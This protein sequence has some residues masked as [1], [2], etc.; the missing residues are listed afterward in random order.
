MSESNVPEE[1]KSK[2]A[3][4]IAEEW[5]GDKSRYEKEW[6][7]DSGPPTWEDMKKAA[8][9]GKPRK[10]SKSIRNSLGSVEKV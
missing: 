8:A 5:L 2:K 10:E 9:M 7:V 6:E 4:K 3:W 1:Y